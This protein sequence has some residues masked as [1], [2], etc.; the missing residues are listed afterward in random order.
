MPSITENLS[1]GRYSWP[2]Q[3]NEWSREWGDVETHWYATIFPRIQLFL[4]VKR[5]LEIAPGYGRWSAFLI[6]N[7]E[8]Y[9]GIDLNPECVAACQSRFSELKNATFVANDGKSLAAVADN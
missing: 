9:I 2:E 8:Q 3:G 1:W 7:A 6:E 4:P 5:L